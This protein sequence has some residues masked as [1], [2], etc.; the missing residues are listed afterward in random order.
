MCISIQSYSVGPS[1]NSFNEEEHIRNSSLL[2][3]YFKWT[4][5]STLII[6]VLSLGTLSPHYF[7]IHIIIINLFS[8]IECKN[9]KILL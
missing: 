9:V 8:K 6:H 7:S 4:S 3:L 5:S 2:L 1:D